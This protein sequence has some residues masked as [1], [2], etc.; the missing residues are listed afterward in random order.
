MKQKINITLDQ[1]DVNLLYDLLRT[2]RLH[3]D[4]ELLIIRGRMKYT[5]TDLFLIEKY[6]SAIERVN[7]LRDQLYKFYEQE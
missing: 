6:K 3:L 7:K 5:E 4:G 2:E 1:E